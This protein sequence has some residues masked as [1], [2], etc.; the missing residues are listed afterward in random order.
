MKH[1]LFNLHESGMANTNKDSSYMLLSCK[2]NVSY[3]FKINKAASTGPYICGSS[4]TN[5]Y[6]VHSSKL[7]A[8]CCPSNRKRP[9]QIQVYNWTIRIQRTF[10]SLLTRLGY[11]LSSTRHILGDL[12]MNVLFVNQNLRFVKQK[13][14]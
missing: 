10:N 1:K 9:K 11:F 7:H 5:I 2:C 3:R 8:A 12:K 6:H 13:L 4:S 14:S